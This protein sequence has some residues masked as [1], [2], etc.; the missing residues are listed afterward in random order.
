MKNS[1]KKTISIA[2]S[3]L[4]VITCYMSTLMTA[5]AVNESADSNTFN[6]INRLVDFDT[7]TP[8]EGNY[9]GDPTPGL[10]AQTAV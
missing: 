4:F 10:T 8:T 5:N 9:W 6:Y 7:Y 1:I 2:F 3:V